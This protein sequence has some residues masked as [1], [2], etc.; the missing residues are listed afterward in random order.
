MIEKQVSIITGYNYCSYL[1]ICCYA[2]ETSNT[3]TCDS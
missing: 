3:E 2:T 1:L